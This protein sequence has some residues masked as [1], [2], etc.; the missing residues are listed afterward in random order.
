[1]QNP[2]PDRITKTE[3]LLF[4]GPHLAQEGQFPP[5]SA[6]PHR[7]PFGLIEAIQTCAP[8]LSAQAQCNSETSLQAL[9]ARRQDLKL[10]GAFHNFFGFSSASC[11]R[12]NDV[13]SAIATGLGLK[14]AG[15]RFGRWAEI[16]GL[17]VNPAPRLGS[18]TR[19]GP[20]FLQ[21]GELRP[22][23]TASE[24]GDPQNGIGFPLSAKHL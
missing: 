18:E 13:P 24:M 12:L 10:S 20:G 19:M 3:P 6:K 17:I 8:S 16:I 22:G 9:G 14:R 23:R 7:C 11:S 5:V 4:S 15:G 1:M 2:Y 21:N